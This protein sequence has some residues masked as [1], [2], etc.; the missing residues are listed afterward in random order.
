MG[1]CYCDRDV[2][3]FTGEDWE[4]GG[5]FFVVKTEQFIG[6]YE[7]QEKTVVRNPGLQIVFFFLERA[8]VRLSHHFGRTKQKGGRP[9]YYNLISEPANANALSTQSKLVCV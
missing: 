1:A 5:D 2:G 4:L 9:S 7:E 3:G 8:C 6:S